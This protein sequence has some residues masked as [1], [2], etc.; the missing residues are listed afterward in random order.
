MLKR[1]EEVLRFLGENCWMAIQWLADIMEYFKHRNVAD[2]RFIS[3]LKMAVKHLQELEVAEEKGRID[4]GLLEISLER[5]RNEFRWLLT[6]NSA[7]LQ[8][9]L[10]TLGEQAS[11]ASSP[12]LVA[13]IQKL[14]AILRRSIA[15]CKKKMV[16]GVR[17]HGAQIESKMQ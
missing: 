12:L 4:G 9:S 10:P 6:E 5:L 16:Q 3:G 17:R 11:I 7:P 2:G 13:V 15:N 1:L 8:M 14:Q